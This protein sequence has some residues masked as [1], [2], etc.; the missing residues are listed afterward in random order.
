[1]CKDELSLLLNPINP[2]KWC[3]W[4]LWLPNSDHIIFARNRTKLVLVDDNFMNEL[5]ANL[6]K[7]LIKFYSTGWNIKKH[8]EIISVFYIYYSIS[9]IIIFACI[10][11]RVY[12]Q[13]NIQYVRLIY[14]KLEIH[15]VGFKIDKHEL[16]LKNYGKPSAPLEPIP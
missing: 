14:F 4:R 11:C 5:G 7:L 1:M 15:D 9:R 2:M 13:R 3:R 16:K 6:W 10:Y 12:T 8:N